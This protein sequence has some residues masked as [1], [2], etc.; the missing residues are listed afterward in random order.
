MAIARAIYADI[1]AGRAVEGGS[2]I[3]EQL[4]KNLLPSRGTAL[5][6]KLQQMIL[7]LW[8]EHRFSKTEILQ[9]YL[10]EVYFGDGAYGIEAAARR[11][12]GKPASKL[13]LNE[14]ALLIGLLPAP[15]LYNPRHDLELATKRARTVLEDM[16]EAG[17]LTQQQAQQT[18]AAGTPAGSTADPTSSPMSVPFP[19]GAGTTLCAASI[20]APQPASS[21][22]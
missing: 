3:T 13:T 10:S 11:Y 16:V 22:Q 20:A 5:H 1:W 12:F 18:V 7:A 2:T 17:F 6:Q 21:P 8:L 15:S 14:S 4:A 9:F 19:N